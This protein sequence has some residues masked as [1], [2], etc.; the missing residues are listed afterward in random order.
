[1]TIDEFQ[2]KLMFG[3]LMCPGCGFLL[4][5]IQ[6]MREIEFGSALIVQVIRCNRCDGTPFLRDI[7]VRG[8][9]KF[10]RYKRNP[11]FVPA[12]KNQR[13]LL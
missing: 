1:M 11:C 2:R 5:V 7:F 13:R 6:N 9:W 10:A 3:R 4:S 12:A 8:D